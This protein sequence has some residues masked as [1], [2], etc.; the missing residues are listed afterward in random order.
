MTPSSAIWKRVCGRYQRMLASRF[1]RHPWPLRLRSAIVSFSFDDFPKTALSVA[2]EI[3]RKYDVVG[4]YYISL[5]L[6]DQDSPSG[7]IFSR[8]DLDVLAAQGHELG[9][10]TYAHSHAWD[11]SPADFERGIV[12]NRRKLAEM[13]PGAEFHSLSYPIGVPRPGTKRN[14]A[15]YFTCSRGGG[16]APNVGEMD[17]NYLKAF[18][19]EQSVHDPAAIRRTIDQNR[20]LPGWLIFATHDVCDRPSRFGCTPE[21]FEEVVRY[22][23][24]SGAR[25]LPVGRAWELIQSETRVNGHDAHAN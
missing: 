19:I 8:P 21:L 11:T 10:H 5:G 20:D 18:F 24:D 17:L 7:P 22:S 25:I 1:D 3:L 2:G 6:M 16:Q 23:V 4:T 12:E 15:K 9:C 14:A 13:L